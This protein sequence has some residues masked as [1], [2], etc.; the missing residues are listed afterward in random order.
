MTPGTCFA[1]CTTKCAVALAHMD[2]PRIAKILCY[3]NG[4]SMTSKTPSPL[5]E[6]PPDTPLRPTLG[7]LIA[8]QGVATTA[9]FDHLL[10]SGADLWTD[11]TE[12]AVF[13]Q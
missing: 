7:D 13:L 6:K 2:H 8:A 9:M 5:A 12:F 4:T 1:R 3:V 11:D 10:G